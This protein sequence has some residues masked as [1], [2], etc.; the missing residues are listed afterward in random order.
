MAFSKKALLVKLL[1]AAS[2]RTIEH[3][4]R[5]FRVF[6]DNMHKMNPQTVKTIDEKLILITKRRGTIR[7]QLNHILGNMSAVDK[8]A[9]AYVVYDIY[10]AVSEYMEGG[11]DQEM[12]QAIMTFDETPA[13]D[14]KAVVELPASLQT[15]LDADGDGELSLSE[16][17]EMDVIIAKLSSS[18]GGTRGAFQ[19]VTCLATVLSSRETTLLF[20]ERMRQRMSG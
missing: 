20:L 6:L 9:L 4:Q 17:H 18:F 15:V 8:L 3:L 10:S 7:E 11:F 2:V 12:A 13:D 16:L 19:A 5:L 14:M 1:K